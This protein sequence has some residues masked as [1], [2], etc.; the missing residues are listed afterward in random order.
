MKS[1]RRYISAWV[2]A[3]FGR[4]SWRVSAVLSAY[5]LL[6][7]LAG[8]ASLFASLP[9]NVILGKGD[10]PMVRSQLNLIASQ[11]FAFFTRPPQ[12]EEINAVRVSGDWSLGESLLHTPQSRVENYFGLSRRQRAQGPELATLVQ[13]VPPESWT[14]C[15]AL[16]T[17][18]CLDYAAGPES[19]ANIIK[20]ASPLATICGD[21]LLTIEQTTKWAYRK[22]EKSRSRIVR[23]VLVSSACNGR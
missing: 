12:S 2:A 3:R 14:D 23:A 21:V 1:G 17:Q 15:G 11:R 16:T 4:T 5:C 22:L 19:K 18:Q 6:L 10:L 9:P 13:A 8:G 7:T 20:N